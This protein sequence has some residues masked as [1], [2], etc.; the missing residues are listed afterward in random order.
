MEGMTRRELQ[1]TDQGQIRRILEQAK[2]LHLG[3]CAGEEPYVLPMNYGFA[4]E[5]GRLTLY[6]HSALKGRKLDLLRENPQV[7][8]S[9][10]CEILPFAGEKPCQYGMSYSC[11][12][13]RGR[14]RLVEDPE[15]KIRA[16]SLLM[17][18]Q[19]GKDFSF[20]EKLVSI[21]AVIRVD[22]SAYTAKHRPLPV[23]MR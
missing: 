13:G 20:D 11:L 2:V 17:K 6:L 7:A 5:D 16:M 8:F 1:I 19:T 9:M 4:L 14:A 21:V 12:M 3:L 10:E 15:E 23:T 18:A 22:V